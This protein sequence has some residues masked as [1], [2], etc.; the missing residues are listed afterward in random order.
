MREGRD[1]GLEVRSP[2]FESYLCYCCGTLGKS[3]VLSAPQFA[4][5]Q[6]ARA[7]TVTSLSCSLH[8]VT[9][10]PP[11]LGPGHSP[12]PPPPGLACL[13]HLPFQKER[14]S[15]FLS[16]RVVVGELAGAGQQTGT[17]VAGTI[18]AIQA[19]RPQG[20]LARS[21]SPRPEIQRGVCLGDP[22]LPLN[23]RALLSPTLR[24]QLC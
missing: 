11:Q 17:G 2:G 6:R 7:G 14:P 15:P 13:P 10:P 8:P 3:P 16:V 20:A 21:Q 4:L 9:L 19:A 1:P 22:G 5:L 23:L 18:P 24:W 12:P